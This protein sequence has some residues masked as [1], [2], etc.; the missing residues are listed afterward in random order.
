MPRALLSSTCAVRTSVLLVAATLGCG[1]A[2]DSV[3]PECSGSSHSIAEIQGNGTASP[4][5]NQRVELSGL[6]SVAPA[7]LGTQSGFFLQSELPGA[8]ARSSDG[9]FVAWE[10]G[11]GMPARGDRVRALGSV[12]ELN[13]VTALAA[14]ELLEPCGHAPLV[15]R[16]LALD[17][18]PLDSL[19]LDAESWEGM[20]IRPRAD[21]TVLDTSLLESRGELGISPSGRAYA[22][23]HPLGQ[24][25]TAGSLWKLLGMADRAR[26]WLATG[27]LSERLRLGA[28][29][30]ELTAIVLSGS[31]PTLLAT[32]PIDF[33][34]PAPTPLKARS[35]GALRVAALN[36][37]NYF[38]QPGTRG[39][40]SELELS[41]QRAKLVAALRQLDAD[42]LALSELENEAVALPTARGQAPPAASLADLISALDSALP[43][44]LA[45]SLSE[46]GADGSDVIRSAIVYRSRRV[47]PSGPAWFAS[48]SEFRRAPLLQSFEV[49]G[50]TLTVGVVHLKSKLCGGTA[51]IIG[52]EGCGAETRRAEA[53]ALAAAVGGLSALASDVLLIGDFNSDSA[54]TP[55]LELKRAGLS[56]LFAGVPAADRYSYVFEG[57]AT[58]LDHALASAALA[59][60]LSNAQIWHIDADEPALFGYGLEHPA[61]AYHSDERRCSDHDPI[62]VDF[63]L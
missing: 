21:W 57:R 39:A 56:D 24:A 9:L 26:A 38:V 19:P 45:Y 20:W 63:A 12:R 36:L 41:R 40:R 3:G 44:E 15:A 62:V 55:V 22:A 50:R 6:V 5:L 2:V 52:D 25:A 27:Q 37:D 32:E 31:P 51:Q 33:R 23:G 46:S 10:S 28:R 58:Q 59:A 11:A 49:P 53:R 54:E 8:D 17:S 4:V 61:E 29:A 30:P 60:A 14:V 13:G 7:Q 42:I 35:S 47:R 34:A 16:R 48:S 1:P 43:S 18:L